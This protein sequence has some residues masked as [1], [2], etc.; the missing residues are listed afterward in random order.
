MKN[1][2][3]T[4]G[5]RSME[6]M[7]TAKTAMREIGRSAARDAAKEAL[8]GAAVYAAVNIAP[9]SKSVA[10]AT[11]SGVFRIAEQVERMHDGEITAIECAEAVSDVCVSVLIGTVFAEAAKQWISHPVLGP[12]LGNAAGVFLYQM[13]SANMKRAVEALP[14][15]QM[16]V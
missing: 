16:A 8:R 10:A 5:E 6:Q 4:Q 2:Q 11:I 15:A 1:H 13:I 9:V 3:Y 14:Q 7:T 12:I